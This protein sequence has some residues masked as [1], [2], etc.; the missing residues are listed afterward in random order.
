ML[1]ISA[2]AFKTVLIVLVLE[3]LSE[4]PSKLLAKPSLIQYDKTYHQDGGGAP[5]GEEDRKF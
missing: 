4:F 2:N 3:G 5:Y 1:E